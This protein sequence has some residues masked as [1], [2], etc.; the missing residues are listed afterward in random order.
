LLEVTVRG[1]EFEIVEGIVAVVERGAA[2]SGRG[3]EVRR[4]EEKEEYEWPAGGE[5][6]R[7]LGDLHFLFLYLDVLTRHF[8]RLIR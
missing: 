6:G 3:V 2:E 5:E 4:E 8:Q 1:V 7:A